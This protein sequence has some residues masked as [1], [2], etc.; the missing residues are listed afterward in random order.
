MTGTPRVAFLTHGGSSIGLGHV[1]RCMALARAFAAASVGA[2]FLVSPDERVAALLAG[3]SLEAT[4]V[5][6]EVAETLAL[7]ALEALRPE[8]VVVDSYAASSDLFAS[9][10]SLAG[11]V[12]AID[13]LADRSL[14]SHVVVNGGVGAESLPYLGAPD[15]LFLLGPRFALVDPRYQ[16]VPRRTATGRVRRVLVSLGGG[17]R[18]GAVATALAAVEG[19]VEDAVVDVVPGPFAAPAS[20]WEAALGGAR[21]RVIVHR[22]VLNLRDL[23]LAADV[24]VSGAGMTLYE[25]AAAGTPAIVVGMSDNQRANVEGFGRAGAALAAGWADE[26]GLREGLAAA[27]RRLVDD[28]DLRARVAARARDLVDGQGALRVAR[29]ILRPVTSRR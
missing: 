13:D 4:E 16:A 18:V 2:R 21:N 15:T 26:P 8:V 5:P 7:E 25:L 23:I 12:V 28:R 17:D 1:S 6:W 27:L 19:T 22:D 20:E 14:P 9:L 10:R 29:E 3:A 24:A 11:Q